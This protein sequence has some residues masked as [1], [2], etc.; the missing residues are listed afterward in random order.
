MTHPAAGPGAPVDDYL[1]RVRRHLA[2]MDSRVRED[3]VRELRA[4]L[5]E[6][7]AANGGN[8]GVAI[9]QMGRPAQV[10]REYKALYGYGSVYRAL[11][12]IFA[13][14]LAVLSVPVLQAGD[15]GPA[16]LGLSVPVLG[17]LVGWLLWV[18]VRAG[19]R[20]G[21][22]AGLVAGLARVVALG[23]A[24]AVNPGAIAPLGELGLFLGTSAVLVV[25]GWLP[26]TAKK[27]WAGPKSEL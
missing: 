23:V 12:L 19:S 16:P 10:G 27:A 3:V 18:G 15:P 25:L 26:G 22:Y 8:V 14:V 21:L 7:V 11:F 1:G 6:S 17:S 5:A 2:G 4:H 20:V 24:A 13:G 9:A